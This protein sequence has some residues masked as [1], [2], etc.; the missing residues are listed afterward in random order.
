MYH[1]AE[2]RWFV[3]GPMPEAVRAWPMVP[4]G[5]PERRT[6]RY[7]LFAGCET[8]GV[9]LREGRFEVKALTG[10]PEV[11]PFGQGI[12]GRVSRWAKWSR[13]EVDVD[14]ADRETWI[15][16]AK[17]RR[18]QTYRVVG[19]RLTGVSTYAHPGCTVEVGTVEVDGAAWWTLAFEAT[20]PEAELR[21]RLH[22]VVAACV[23]AAPLADGVV[24][25]LGHSLAYP[26]FLAGLAG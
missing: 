11:V 2:V 14:P 16:V 12:A 19:G 1:T 10:P 9:K 21:W 23:E 20:G 22:R 15:E 7:L 24:L 8:V 4:A 18:Q 25:R 3:P 6:D 17:A 5:T 13:S 26:A